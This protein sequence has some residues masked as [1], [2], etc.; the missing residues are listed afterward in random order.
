MVVGQN[1]YA[2]PLFKLALDINSQ[3]E[4]FWLYY[5]DTLITAERFA[6]AERI[7]VKSEKS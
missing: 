5:L 4:Q 1:L 2:P 3:I 7:V 6:D